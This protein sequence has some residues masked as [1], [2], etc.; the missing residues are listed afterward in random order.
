MPTLCL[1]IDTTAIDGILRLYPCHG[2]GG[3]QFFAFEKSGQIVSVEEH[4]VGINHS[5][6]VVLVHC[7]NTDKTQ[8]WTFNQKVSVCKFFHENVLMKL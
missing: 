2:Y 1:D 6:D 4:C 3:Q 7:S 5:N 8:R